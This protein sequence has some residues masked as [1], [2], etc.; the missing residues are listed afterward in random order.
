MSCLPQKKGRLFLHGFVFLILHLALTG[1]VTATGIVNP[2]ET[3]WHISAQ[4]VTFDSKRQLYIAEDDVVITGGKTRLE[5]DYVEFSNQTKDAFAQGDVLLISGKD[6]IRCD[7][8]QI[9]LATETGSIRK[10]SIFIE[11][12][13]FHIVGENIKKTGKFSYSADKGSI[14]SCSG[15]VPDW[16]ISAKEISVSIEGYGKASHTVLWAKNAPVLYSPYLIFPARTKRQTGLL[17]PRVSS[18]DRKGLEY[19]QPLFWA[20]SRD[21]DA[22]FYANYMSERGTKVGAEYRYMVNNRSKGSIHL[23]ILEDEKIDDGTD[24]TIDY[25]FDATPQRTNTDRFWFRMKNDQQLPNGFTAK[26]DIDVVS[27]EDYL[28]EFRDGFTGYDETKEYFEAVHGRSLDEYDDFTRKNTLSLTKSWSNYSFKV[29]GIWFDDVRARRA[30]TADT[31]LQT[32]PSFRFDV[33]KQ[34]LGTFPFYYSLETEHTSF[35]RKETTS[36][37]VK[38]QRTDLYPRFSAPLKL[39]RF[40]TFEPSLGLRE[41]IYYTN[42][43]TDSEGNSESFR[44]RELYDMEAVLSSKVIKIFDTANAFAE[45]I[46]H[47]ITPELTYAFTPYTGQDTLPFFDDTDRIEEEN[48]L[49]WSITNRFITRKN[50]TTP[51]GE[52]SAFYREIAY[53]KLSQS[54]D[55]KRERDNLPDPFSDLSLEIEFNPGDFLTL[56]SE[57]D[58]SPNSNEFTLFNVG[59]TIRDYRGDSL[60]TEYRY[61][62]DLSESLYGKVDIRINDRLSCYYSVEKNLMDDKTVETRAGLSYKKACWWFNLFFEESN[63]ETSIAFLIN[64]VGIGAFGTK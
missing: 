6:S 37:L 21:I 43:F 8:M 41:T 40:F 52:T 57:I 4:V 24:A 47:E 33:A 26:L 5:A 10:G 19:E 27:D 3:S 12:S 44:T 31:T 50:R 54:Y 45:K 36:T 38:G 39:G 30:D 34:R 20:I 23:D 49:T 56:D 16:K 18:S 17:I 46:K 9:N 14:T 29:D 53:I 48:R 61:E 64:L 62:Q 2:E 1:V 11:E 51:Q 32:L 15:D 42:D 13:N 60:R 7:A 22:T 59:S 35:Y 28:H 63:N 25:R 55:I 58:W